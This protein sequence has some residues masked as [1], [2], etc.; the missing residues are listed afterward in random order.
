M[1]FTRPPAATMKEM[2]CLLVLLFHAAPCHAQTKRAPRNLQQAVIFLNTDCPDSLKQVIK[3]T[4]DK[5]LAEFAYPWHGEYKTIFEWTK[6]DEPSRLSKRLTS[7]GITIGQDQVVLIAFK[8]FLLGQRLN[9][10]VLYQPFQA[11]GQKLAAEDNVRF[12]TDSLRGV[13][14]P[15]DLDDCIGRIDAMWNDS[16]KQKV[17]GWTEEEFSGGAHL[18]FGTWM[19]N[20]WQLWAGSRL[21]SFFNALGVHNP[22]D[23]TGIILT[24]YHRHLARMALDLPAQV[25]FYQAYWEKVHQQEAAQEAQRFAAYHVGDTI[26][27]RYPSGYVT[28]AQEAKYDDDTCIATG[29]V[30][31]KNGEKQWL[32]VQL[33]KSC[34]H[35][36]I[37]SYDSK[38]TLTFNGKTHTWEVP[39]HRV[40]KRM[41]Q[42]QT[43]W[44]AHTEWEPKE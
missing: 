36:G 8:R 25:H 28:K 11:L 21:S 20:N 5:D 12:T 35:K 27:Y 1:K 38:N 17:K 29:R 19:R 14:I 9:E 32:N 42:G 6:R 39:P 22:E 33:L 34:D 23:M 43:R 13:Y 41:R 44:F 16:T 7:K 40:I 15:K 3:T 4:P 26:T 10:R 31:G 37:I 24:S 18:G 2:T 30:V